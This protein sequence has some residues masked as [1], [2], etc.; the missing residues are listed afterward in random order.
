ML[1]VRGTILI[2]QIAP[3]LRNRYLNRGFPS[4][5]VKGKRGMLKEYG[6]SKKQRHLAQYGA[7]KKLLEEMML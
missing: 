1:D 7:L 4:H 6:N 5:L 2:M 3:N